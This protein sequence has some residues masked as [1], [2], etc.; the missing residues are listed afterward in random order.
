MSL[1]TLTPPMLLLPYSVFGGDQWSQ[2]GPFLLFVIDLGSR[3]NKGTTPPNHSL[4]P[5]VQ[6]TKKNAEKLKVL[7][8]NIDE[9]CRSLIDQLEVAL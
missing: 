4:V 7:R 5:E 3:P 8:S 9:V 1:V 6:D 2:G